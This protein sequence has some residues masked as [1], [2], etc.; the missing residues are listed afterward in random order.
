MKTLFSYKKICIL[1]VLLICLQGVIFAEGQVEYAPKDADYL[2]IW[3]RDMDNTKLIMDLTE[4]YKKLNP[5]FNLKLEVVA[6]D[7]LRQKVQVLV[8]GGSLPDAF[9]YES[10]TP[11]IE[12]IDAGLL[13][14]MEKT[15][16]GLGIMDV[17]DPG[18][19]SLLKK[20]AGNKGLYDLPLGMNVEGIWYN[21][22]IFK[23]LG[24]QPP[25][26]WSEL[27]K[28]C[29]TLLANGIQPF[30]AGGKDKWPITRLVNMY[31]MRKMG[32]DAVGKASKG[33]IS[34][35][36]PAF[37]EAGTV[38][39]DMVKKG[40]FGKGIVTVDYA[41]ARAT[42][43]SGKAA[44]LYNG[45]WFAGDLN[46]PELNTLGPDGVGF[47]N[48]PLV[49][50]GK[51]AMGDYSVNCGHIIAFS[52]AKYD[53]QT[54]AW[55][56]YVFSRFGDYAMETQ[57]TYKGFRVNKMPADQ[58]AYTKLVQEELNKV[59]TAGLWFEATMDNKTA[60]IAEDQCQSLFLLDITPL[61]F[62]QKLE[63]SSA[64]YRNK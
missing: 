35:T 19:V 18:A 37:I 10:G 62:F 56:K 57:G 1:L 39:Q 58:S 60:K 42:L 53:A 24:L 61:E 26:T 7:N 52:A 2:S 30:T 5:D 32:V 43:F 31:V 29:D 54:G 40:Y 3:A 28:V 59:K 14:D 11:I 36:D 50:G 34:F 46:N 4:E 33:E 22:K 12:L 6:N 64:E 41:G 63:K 15:F 45:S 44:M 20:L 55:L 23:D 9:I 21:K 8:A 48:I 13:L 27:M 38:I 17:I 51:G 49:E 25:K 47:F 16:T